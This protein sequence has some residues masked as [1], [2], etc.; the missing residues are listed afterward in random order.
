MNEIYDTIVWLANPAGKLFPIVRFT[1]DTDMVTEGWVSLTS[2]ERPE[3]VVTQAT[4]EEWNSLE[5]TGASQIE[6]RINRQLGRNDL[7]YV[8]LMRVEDQG[9]PKGVSFQ[10]FRKAYKP[11][12]L[13]YQDIYSPTSQ[14]SEVSQTTR[15]DFER[16]GGKVLVI[17]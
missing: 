10:E 14:A 13:L 7:R 3:V 8:R 16:G 4:A 1:G 5:S 6:A 15:A 2:T 12:K 9:N 11:P 17:T